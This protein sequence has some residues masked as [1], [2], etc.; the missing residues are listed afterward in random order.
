[1]GAVQREPETATTAVAWMLIVAALLGWVGSVPAPLPWDLD[2]R[3]ALPAV[4]ALKVAA[5][6]VGLIAL[7]SFRRRT[8]IAVGFDRMGTAAA[9]A[10]VAVVARVM[11][12]QSA[13]HQVG[14]PDE[15]VA[16]GVGL[17]VNQGIASDTFR[18]PPRPEPWLQLGVT[19]LGAEVLLP[20]MLA[21]GV[22]GL[23]VIASVTPI[24][25]VLV[26]W[27]GTRMLRMGASARLLLLSIASAVGGVTAVM[28]ASVAVA[29]RRAELGFSLIVAGAISVVLIHLLPPVAALVHVDVY[30]LG[31]WL[32][33]TLDAAS[34]TFAA[35]S[36][37]NPQATALASTLTQVQ[38]SMLGLVALTLSIFWLVGHAH[39]RRTS[40]GPPPLLGI[41][42]PVIGMLL[43][44]VFASFVLSHVLG[45]DAMHE[46][47]GI[48][49]ELRGWCFSVAAAALGM[50]LHARAVASEADHGRSLALV[51]FGVFADAALTLLLAQQVLGHG[52]H[53]GAP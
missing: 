39:D 36:L 34:I 15:C 9:V 23:V 8:P 7:T 2:P 19:W 49:G 53:A 52:L 38:H 43:A 45:P 48:T 37:H 27:V 21:L 11:N 18:Q 44:S 4:H 1:M 41:P 12:H 51:A 40:D 20:R 3:V 30:L 42:T 35:G 22:P 24:V 46:L 50:S 17:L 14:V 13:I 47:V 6:L 5:L 16:F 28:M 26:W 10:L 32:G 25:I 31:A 33:G 29:A